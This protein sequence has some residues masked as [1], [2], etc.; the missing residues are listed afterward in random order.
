MELLD[1]IGELQL[2][3]TSLE[4][5]T[6]ELLCRLKE[7]PQPKKHSTPLRETLM[8]DLEATFLQPPTEIDNEWLN[9]VQ[10]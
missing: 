7:K 3:A 8:Q 10:Q 2:E 9:R 4:S 1:A 6:D 5:Q